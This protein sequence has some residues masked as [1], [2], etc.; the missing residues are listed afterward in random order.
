[1]SITPQLPQ[2]PPPQVPQQQGMLPVENIFHHTLSG[3]GLNTNFINF[4]EVDDYNENFFNPNT[5]QQ[6]QQQRPL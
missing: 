6:Q 4:D 2:P 3:I 5:S 1:M